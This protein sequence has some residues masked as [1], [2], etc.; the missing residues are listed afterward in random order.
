MYDKCWR[1]THGFVNSDPDGGVITLGQDE[2]LS[3]MAVNALQ[4]VRTLL[5]YS[6]KRTLGPWGDQQRFT[7]DTVQGAIV[8]FFG[9]NKDGHITGIGV[10]TRNP[11]TSSGSSAPDAGTQV[12]SSRYEHMNDVPRFVI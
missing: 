8:G 7:G 12:V 5:L 9:S 11:S 3:E 2:L 10:W 4:T 1:L 6:N